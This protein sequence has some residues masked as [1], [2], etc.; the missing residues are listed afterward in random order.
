MNIL[1]FAGLSEKKLLSKLSPI[2]NNN[3]INKIYIIRK[4][5]LFN[6]KINCIS[7]GLKI[8]RNSYLF[9]IYRIF[10]AISLILFKDINIIMSIQM[11]YHG[12]IGFLL[13]KIFNKYFI[14]NLVESFDKLKMSKFKSNIIKNSN[15]LIT[16][17]STVQK[18]LNDFFNTEICSKYVPNHYTF[19]DD[20][21]NLFKD[22]SII[23]CGTFTESKRL[24]ILTEALFQ[25]KT[26]YKVK[27]F[28][29]KMYGDGPLKNKIIDKIDKLGLNDNIKIFGFTN[30]IEKIISESRIAIMTSEFEGQ[31][32]FAIESLGLGIPCIMPNIS[33]IPEVAIHNYN[34]LLVEP[35]DVEGFADAIYQLMTDDELYKRLK[36]GAENFRKE[37]E[38]EYSMENITNIWNEILIKIE[39]DK[40]VK[41]L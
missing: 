41:Q 16:R 33:N 18:D 7:P 34:S 27:Y 23:Y 32:M 30:N 40:R 14:F 12:I 38:Y 15:F 31:P 26:N 19:F 24:D 9:E 39:T 37:H 20:N 2:I 36:K 4:S 1:I 11:M 35:L 22:Q 8:F 5:A 25:L 17:G 10:V 29:V 3:Q 13:S 6:E 28:I 21:Y